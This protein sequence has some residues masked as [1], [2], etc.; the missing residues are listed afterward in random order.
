ME[1]KHFFPTHD[2]LKHDPNRNPEFQYEMRK[3][4]LETKLDVVESCFGICNTDFKKSSAPDATWFKK[5]YQKFFHSNVL[6]DRELEHYTM[7]V[8][9]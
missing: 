1:S 8:D 4:M 5:C 2:R 6:I 9:K 7:K 3:G